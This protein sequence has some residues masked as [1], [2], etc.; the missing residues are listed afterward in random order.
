MNGVAGQGVA[1]A[2]FWILHSLTIEEIV[3]TAF[4]SIQ[5]PLI[6]RLDYKE[7]KA[8]SFKLSPSGLFCFGN[9]RLHLL[10]CGLGSESSTQSV[11]FQSS[12]HG[13]LLQ[14]TVIFKQMYFQSLA[15]I[16]KRG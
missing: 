2:G 6:K 16:C 3:C 5:G 9:M 12:S 1:E 13:R 7:I 8:S 10:L 15:D 14:Y 11:F 4:V